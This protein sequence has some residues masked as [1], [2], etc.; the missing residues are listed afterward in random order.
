MAQSTTEKVTKAGDKAVEQAN[1]ATRRLRGLVERAKGAIGKGADSSSARPASGTPIPGT[2]AA[3]P[4]AAAGQ[5]RTTGK[6]AGALDRG[7]ARIEELLVAPNEQSMTY[8]ITPR[9]SHLG[10]IVSKGSRVAVSYDGI[11]G[12]AFDRL[13]QSVNGASISFS[14]DGSRFAYIGEAD[15]KF[16]YMVDGKEV[17]R[18][19]AITQPGV[20]GTLRL[21][22]SPNGK[23]WFAHYSNLAALNA[24]ADPAR[25]W[26]D[27]RQGPLGASKE[28]TIS[29]DGERHAYIATDPATGRATLVVDGKPAPGIGGNPVFTSDGRHL[30]TTRDASPA[31]GRPATELL[32]DG[33]V[34]VRSTNVA[35]HMPPVGDRVVVVLLRDDSPGGSGA[36]SLFVDG[37]RIPG[38]DASG[39]SKITFSADGKRFAVVSG[40]AGARQRIFADGK[41]GRVYDAIDSVWFSPDSKHLA[42]TA[43]AGSK[44]FVITDDVESEIG[45]AANE[46][47]VPRFGKGGRAGWLASTGSG[48][49]VVVDNRVTQLDPRG[50]AFDFSFSPDG[51]RFAYVASSDRSGQSGGNVFVDHV[52][53]PPSLLRDFAQY[54]NGDPV[55]Y[56][57]TPDGRYTVHYAAPGTRFGNDFGFVIGGRYL[58]Q[59]NMSRV[60]LP[61]FTPDGKHLFWLVEDGQR[62]VMRLFVDGRPIFEYD[63]DGRDPLKVPGGWVMGDDGVL[64]FFIQTV[65]GFKRMR[66]TPGPENGFESWLAQG[67]PLR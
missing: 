56:I 7:S 10:A 52:S 11:V 8:Y 35:V 3:G 61:T 2:D 4:S 47:I 66:V 45:F 1:A 53:G 63:A 41:A 43:R 32:L 49:A 9:G 54:R 28:L 17:L 42:Y 34:V 21:F 30:Y 24:V 38:S 15:G 51:S 25:N 50:S 26:W 6:T 67:K 5:S 55:R 20:T 44:V 62:S 39:Y 57:W 16:V 19:P 46:R 37:Q 14:P 13:L 36:Y 58:S 31:Q 48:L 29:P 60:V 64:S 59:G 65:D 33:R 22:F 27:G 23:H 12:P 18:L 40:M